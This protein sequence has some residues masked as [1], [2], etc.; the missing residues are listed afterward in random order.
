MILVKQHLPILLVFIKLF[1]FQTT[2]FWWWRE[3]LK[4]EKQKNWFPDIFLT[5][6]NLLRIFPDRLILKLLK[7]RKQKELYMIISDCLRLFLL[8]I[9]LHGEK[10]IFMLLNY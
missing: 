10:K 6:Q 5:F 3:I 8:I 2:L 4:S 9:F 7:H 1:M